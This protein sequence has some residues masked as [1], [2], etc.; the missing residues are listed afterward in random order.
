MELLWLFHFIPYLLQRYKFRLNNYTFSCR[1]LPRLGNFCWDWRRFENQGRDIQNQK[2][3][4]RKH[5]LGNI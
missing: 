1:K 5:R 4:R 2:L 3:R